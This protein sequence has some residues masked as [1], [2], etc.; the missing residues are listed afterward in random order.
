MSCK[1]KREEAQ[2]PTDAIV[3]SIRLFDSV[4]EASSLGRARSAATAVRRDPGSRERHQH[5]GASEPSPAITTSS[6]KATAPGRRARDGVPPCRR[7]GE[8]APRGSV[9]EVALTQAAP[10]LQLAQAATARRGGRSISARASAPSSVRAKRIIQF[11]TSA[12][13]EAMDRLRSTSSPALGMRRLSNV[14]RFSCRREREARSADRRD[15]LLQSV[16]VE[17]LPGGAEP[18]S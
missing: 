1:R 17:R 5:G 2:P 3:C 13:G 18:R 8:E 15:C 11:V 14:S 10:T 4:R 9:G 16:V 12:P 7:E 6:T